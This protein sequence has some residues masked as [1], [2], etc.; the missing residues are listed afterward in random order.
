MLQMVYLEI[1]SVT[2]I[3]VLSEAVSH[4]GSESYS[5]LVQPVE[6]YSNKQIIV[7]AH[8][9]VNATYHYRISV[10]VP[11]NKSNPSEILESE[12]GN[13]CQGVP[14]SKY[15]VSVDPIRSDHSLLVYQRVITGSNSTQTRLL[16]HHVDGLTNIGVTVHAYSEDFHYSYSNGY[17]LGMFS[18][19]F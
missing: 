6:W 19:Q 1:A 10:V 2:P 5:I 13:Y 15:G 11:S 8:P 16:L 18:L 17:T 4:S 3:V 14:V 9:F 12:I 7:L